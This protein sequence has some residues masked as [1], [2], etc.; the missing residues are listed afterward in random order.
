MAQLRLVMITTTINPVITITNTKSKLLSSPISKKNNAFVMTLKLQMKWISHNLSS[1]LC[2]NLLLSLSPT[3]HIS[4]KPPNWCHLNHLDPTK[5]HLTPLVPLVLS[6]HPAF[7]QTFQP[8]T[9]PLTSYHPN[10]PPTS[11]NFTPNW[12][13]LTPLA[14]Y[15]CYVPRYWNFAFCWKLS[16]IHALQVSKQIYDKLVHDYIPHSASFL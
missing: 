15:W 1:I 7:D 6:S 5:P 4:L 8:F 13:H 2:P 12:P 10:S 9:Q 11:L 14:C 3:S 16:S